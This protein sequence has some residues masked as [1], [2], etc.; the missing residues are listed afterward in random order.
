MEPQTSNKVISIQE[1]EGVNEREKFGAGKL[2][3]FD[4]ILG[5]YTPS[6]ELLQEVPGKLFLQHFPAG[7]KQ[8]H[9]TNDSRQNIIFQCDDNVYVM[10]E[11]DLFNRALATNLIPVPTTEEEDM[12]QAIIAHVA[13]GINTGGGATVANV[14]T[15]RPLTNIISQFNADGTAAAFATLVGNVITLSSGWYRIYGWCMGSDASIAQNIVS[16][17]RIQAGAALWAGLLNENSSFEK[18]TA[19]NRN[20]RM[21]FGGVYHA[22]APVNIVLETRSTSSQAATGFG[23]FAA[24]AGFNDIYA[25]ISILRTGP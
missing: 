22:V 13:A 3:E 18:V 1:L 21:E 10:S 25:W 8:I 11:A 15:Q 17:L 4:R 19:A 9:Q 14:F 23:N 12:S 6:A 2:G 24:S 20:V 7:V 5:L 16:R